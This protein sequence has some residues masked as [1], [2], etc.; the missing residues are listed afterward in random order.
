VPE[1]GGDHPLAAL[2]AERAADQ[3]FREAVAVALGRV[4]EVDAPVLR[5]RKEPLDVFERERPAPLASEL[6]R[7]ESDRRND[8]TGLAEG[9]VFHRPGLPS[10]VRG[11]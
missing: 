2:A 4:D 11:W 6:P 8:E 1:L 7:P 3:R 5:V 9:P 10:W